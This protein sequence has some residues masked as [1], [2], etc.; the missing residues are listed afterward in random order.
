M[1][2][3]TTQQSLYRHCLR[4]LQR[5]CARVNANTTCRWPQL[6]SIFPIRIRGSQLKPALRSPDDR[7]FLS[8]FGIQLYCA[9][10][11]RYG[12]RPNVLNYRQHSSSRVG[13]SY[14]CCCLVG[15]STVVPTPVA[16]LLLPS[17]FMAHL[18]TNQSRWK[19]TRYTAD[20]PAL[21][22]IYMLWCGTWH[23]TSNHARR[24]TVQYQQLLTRAKDA[25]CHR[26]HLSQVDTSR[27]METLTQ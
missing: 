21:Y 20:W 6:R 22:T 10:S 23:N 26:I 25:K 15:D 27:R 8:I 7:S 24:S 11:L 5:D 13:L 14:L 16:K 9:T 18:D 17:R 12:I 2:N 4:Q 3:H 1:Q 19:Q